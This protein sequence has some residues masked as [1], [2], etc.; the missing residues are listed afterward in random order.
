MPLFHGV[1]T[2]LVTPFREDERI[3]FNAWQAIIDAQIG[4]GVDGVLAAGGP[5]EFFSLSTEER[6]VAVRFVRQYVGRRVPVYAHV[7]YAGTRPTV[8]LAEQAAAEGVACLVA[9]TPYYVRPND[10]ELAEHFIEICRSVHLPVLA[11]NNPEHTGVDLTPAV[12]Q[13]I[14]AAC[15]NF[16]GVQDTAGGVDRIAELAAIGTPERPFAAMTGRGDLLLPALQRG[17]TGT[18]SASANVAPRLVVELFRA[19]CTG[20]TARAARL[21][22]LAEPLSQACHLHT[23]PAAVKEAL[24]IIGLPPGPCRRPIGPL[25]ADAR[26]QL[27]EVLDR[28]RA[29]RYLPE[30]HA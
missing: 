19:F 12:A 16:A 18:L 13:R 1:V 26:N 17:C 30:D 3:D 8:Q 24:T 15:D 4:A 27:M 11:A 10:D 22:A 21:Q 25:A 2:A 29:E 7:G 9:V 14:A 6:L 28:L 5:G 23:F 20:D